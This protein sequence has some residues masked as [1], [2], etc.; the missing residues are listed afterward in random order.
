MKK[1]MKKFPVY[2]I[3]FYSAD[4]PVI[5][6]FYYFTRNLF[7]RTQNEELLKAISDEMML[8]E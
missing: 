5:T 4:N 6:G 3:S 8:V 2:R 1:S 7:D